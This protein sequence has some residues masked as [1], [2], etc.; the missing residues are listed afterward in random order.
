MIIDDY[1]GDNFDHTGL[2]FFGAAIWVSGR[3][4][5]VRSRPAGAK[6]RRNGRTVEEGDSRDLSTRLQPG[7]P[8][9]FL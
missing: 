1:N 6:A 5:H 9:Q 3:P 7:H 4:T 2:G 8:W